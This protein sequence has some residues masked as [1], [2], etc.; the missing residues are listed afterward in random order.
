MRMC[1]TAMAAA[2]LALG[3]VASSPVSAEILLTKARTNA[4]NVPND[5]VP[6]PL[7]NAGTNFLTF[8]ATKKGIVVITYNAECAATG[9][10]GDFVGLQ[11]RVDG[12]P[13]NPKTVAGEFAFCTASG[14]TEI[15][16]A[17]SRQAFINVKE[18][19]HIVEVIISRFGAASGRID[20]SSIVI[21]D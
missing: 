16:T 12:K 17:V 11:I 1:T 13:T 2:T 14:V 5:A 6:A 18:G 4:Y 20:D 7:D 9:T 8:N 21:F 15:F 3:V 10:A 19:S